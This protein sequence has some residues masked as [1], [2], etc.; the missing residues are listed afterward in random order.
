MLLRNLRWEVADV[1]SER[2]VATIIP[3]TDIER[4]KNNI[5]ALFESQK[6]G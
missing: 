2:R 5:P 4:A 3:A 6:Y 1:W